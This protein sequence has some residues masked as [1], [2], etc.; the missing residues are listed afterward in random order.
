MPDT[1]SVQTLAFTKEDFA[2]LEVEGFTERMAALRTRLTPKL[3]EIG[4]RLRPDLE[5]ATGRT[6]YVHVARH[7][8]RTVNPPK[9]TWVAVSE[10]PRGYKMVPHFSVGLFS[11]RLFLRVGALYEADARGDFAEVLRASL[12]GLPPDA[13]VVFDHQQPGGVPVSILHAQSDR[14][15]QSAM[16]RQGEV[17]LERSRSADAVVGH[18]LLAL[19]RPLLPPLVD[20]Y[21][22]WRRGADLG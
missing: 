2:V 19:V 3:Q 14:I 12:K 4:E 21:M 13:E 11:D 9:D 16:R 6:L 15:V 17:L 22:E 1:A 10:M 8:R 5:A 7:A 18:D 20:V